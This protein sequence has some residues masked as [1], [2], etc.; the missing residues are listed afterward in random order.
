MQLGRRLPIEQLPQAAYAGLQDSAPRAALLSLHARVASVEPQSWE[1]QRFVQVWG[2]REAAYLVPADATAAFTLGRLPRDERLRAEEL[3]LADTVLAA[4]DGEACRSN[5]LAARLG[6]ADAALIRRGAKSGRVL[7]RW[8]TRTTTVVPVDR[9]EGIEEDARLDLARRYATWFG[10]FGGHQHFA[11]WA[12]VLLEDAQVTWERLDWQP[13]LD[14]PPAE[15][16]RFVPKGDPC[17]YGLR[18]PD[19]KPG[20][21]AGAVLIGAELVGSWTRRGLTVTVSLYR[22]LSPREMEEVTAE[23][24][25]LE[26]VLDG[27]ITLIMQDP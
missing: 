19:D 14:G 21:V 24:D 16:I 3:D 11:T 1:D 25:L 4:L 17:L 7:L 20:R 2:P 10:C 27:A 15:G 6:I 9:P 23:I 22:Q 13:P 12:G 18:L 5:D 8:D 26:P